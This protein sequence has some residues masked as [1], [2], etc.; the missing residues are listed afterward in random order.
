MLDKVFQHRPWRLT[1]GALALSGAAVIAACDDSPSTPTEAGTLQ[2]MLTDAPMQAVDRVNVFVTGVTVKRLNRQPEAV[3]LNLT[4]NPVDLL[5]LQNRVVTL[6][7]GD[8]EAGQYEYVEIRLDES[9]S[10]IVESGTTRPVDIANETIRIVH[11]FNIDEDVRTVVTLDFDAAAS[12]TRLPNGNWVL[13]PVVRV[14]S[15]IAN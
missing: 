15:N 10:S 13:S 14:T 9:R 2:I 4:P 11:T 7:A 8:V 1:M 12:L 6:A 3:L 5:T